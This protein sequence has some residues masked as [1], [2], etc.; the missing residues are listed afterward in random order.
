M[1]RLLNIWISFQMVSGTTSGWVGT[2][3]NSNWSLNVAIYAWY[4]EF[5]FDFSLIFFE[6]QTT[7]KLKKKLI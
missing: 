6:F 5:D 4:Q 1:W 7:G 2:T 3:Y